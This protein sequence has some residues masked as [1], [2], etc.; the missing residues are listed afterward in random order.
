MTLLLKLVIILLFPVTES[1]SLVSDFSQGFQCWDA[2]GRLEA[3]CCPSVQE[4]DPT[5]L[6]QP[7]GLICPG[8]DLLFPK[9]L[10]QGPLKRHS[11]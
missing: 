8:R 11:E 3:Q 2:R 10:S 9:A 4:L 6:H 7:R 1:A 5:E